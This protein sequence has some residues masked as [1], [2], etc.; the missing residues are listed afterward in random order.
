[1]KHVIALVTGLASL[2]TGSAFAAQK[3]GQPLDERAPDVTY[4][5]TCGYCHG[6]NV[7]PVIL[8]RALDPAIVKT[9]VRH[10]RNGMPAFRP[11][12]IADGELSALADW[13]SKSKSVAT[14]SGH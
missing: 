10:G 13:I 4:A 2:I 6:R 8:G 5:K 11:T 3:L 14:E 9:M 1:M 12:E 7:G